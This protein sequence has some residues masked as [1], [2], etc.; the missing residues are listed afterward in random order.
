MKLSLLVFLYLLNFDIF[1][2]GRKFTISHE[3][4]SITEQAEDWMEDIRF[5]LKR[6]DR[7]KK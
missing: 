4:K 2:D 5:D 1:T 6:N 3:T 7:K